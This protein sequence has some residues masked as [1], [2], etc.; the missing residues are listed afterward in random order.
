MVYLRLIKVISIVLALISCLVA[1]GCAVK[2]IVKENANAAEAANG[3]E[4][5]P[6]LLR[7][8]DVG[9]GGLYQSVENLQK[10]K[11]VAEYLHQEGIPFHVSL[12]PRMTVPRKGYDVSITDQTP[13]AKEF[14][15]TIKYLEGIGGI[16]GVHG[17]THQSGEDASGI[18]FEFYDKSKNPGVPNTLNYSRGRVASAIELFERAGIKPAYWETPHYTASMN[19]YQ[20]FE[21]QIG[22][23]YEDK[24]RGAN[25]AKPQ[26]LDYDGR[27]YR[28]YTT[29]PT[30][31]GY[32]NT[33][34][35]MAKVIALSETRKE[36]LASF[37]YHPFKEFKY[38]DVSYD[39]QGAA[40]FTYDPDSPLHK[41]VKSFKEKGYTFVSIYSLAMF[42]PA[43][44]LEAVPFSKGDRIVAGR[45][46]K[47]EGNCILIMDRLEKRWHMYSYIPKWYVPRKR[48][49]FENRGVWLEGCSPLDGDVVTAVDVNADKL[50]DLLTYSPGE[51]SFIINR[52]KGNCFEKPEV[53]GNLYAGSKRS[54]IPVSG[55]YNGDGLFD[56]AA[57]ERD[58]GRLGIALNT[59]TGFKKFSWKTIDVLRGDFHNK[60]LSG[61]YNG[62]LRS[63]IAFLH[64][65]S[66]R[67]EVLLAGPEGEFAAK[68]S[69]WMENWGEGDQWVPF[70]SDVNADGLSDVVLYNRKGHWQVAVSDGN[71]FK[72]LGDFGPWGSGTGGLPMLADLNGDRKSDL[73]IVDNSGEDSYNLDTALSVLP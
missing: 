47:G 59:G 38:I 64:S 33:N 24:Y 39:E 21:E 12:I 55:D 30:P 25:F 15:N 17:Y 46:V 23:I 63:D 22:L 35:D 8:E 9:P 56:V 66:G 73:I 34:R 41:L 65:P 37:F 18:G 27:G 28:G 67:W 40:H 45:F 19:Q 10:L 4:K 51:G 57:V 5:R 71:S 50:D 48:H 26:T 2:E 68:S 3:L 20:A 52:N 70:A 60:Y 32:I 44:R 42:V 58:T 53:I 1:G 69:I 6:A 36:N 13:Y 43:H 49:A 29:I 7:L 62:D 14:V 54:L 72:F 31:L 11:I 61:D 16:I